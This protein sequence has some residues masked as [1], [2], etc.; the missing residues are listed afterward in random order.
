MVNLAATEYL[1]NQFHWEFIVAGRNW[2]MRR[3]NA[4]LTHW[5]EILLANFVSP[6]GARVLVEQFERE[7]ARMA[8]VHVVTLDPSIAKDMQDPHAADSEDDF[9]ATAIVC[10][11]AIEIIDKGTIVL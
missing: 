11:T 8:F 3:E 1:V 10:I 7:K 5:V 4:S 6:F 9:L 2:G